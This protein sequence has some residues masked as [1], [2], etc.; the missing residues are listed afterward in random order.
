RRDW[1]PPDVHFKSDA[2]LAQ[3]DPPRN[4]H[5]LNLARLHYATFWH[6]CAAYDVRNGGPMDLDLFTGCVTRLASA[7]DT[8][9]AFLGLIQGLGTKPKPAREAWRPAHPDPRTFQL[10]TYR[11]HLVHGAPFMQVVS[12]S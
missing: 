4:K 7:T 6:L 8:S 2:E 11:N 12:G 1:T 10:R 5:D 9:D 3:L